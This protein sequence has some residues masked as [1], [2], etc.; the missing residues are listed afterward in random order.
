MHYS[1]ES[2]LEIKHGMGKTAIDFH[3][4]SLLRKENI[5]QTPYT[6]RGKSAGNDKWYPIQSRITKRPNYAGKYSNPCTGFNNVKINRVNATTKS[7]DS[8]LP[9]IKMCVINCQS[10]RNKADVLVDYIKDN[11]LDMVAMTET[12]LK[13]D[14]NRIVGD[15]T[16]SGLILVHLPR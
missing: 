12:W 5:C 1:R 4:L 10:I 3:I 6:V 8:V 11:N 13:S 9:Q 16:R 7:P 2:L 14:D 15:L